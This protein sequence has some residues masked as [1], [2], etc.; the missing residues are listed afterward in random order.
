MVF[1]KTRKA[2]R[3]SLPLIRRL[4]R[5][6]NVETD[7]QR[8]H[9]VNITGEQVADGAAA[10]TEAP[11]D[12]PSQT[13]RSTGH[14]D[15]GTLDRTP[16]VIQDDVIECIL[17]ELEIQA[18]GTE[19]DESRIDE[20]SPAAANS[21]TANNTNQAQISSDVS[22]DSPGDI[23]V[24][25][26]PRLIYPVLAVGALTTLAVVI[27]S[28]YLFS[29]LETRMHGPVIRLYN[30]HIHLGI[31]GLVGGNAKIDYI[32]TGFFCLLF[33]GT[34]LWFAVMTHREV[35]GRHAGENIAMESMT[36][37]SG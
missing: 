34:L 6:Q 31:R 32:S 8:H 35:V 3:R 5:G 29:S 22:I 18:A 1:T 17:E 23:D 24:F 11:T 10:E 12:A 9:S 26:N 30:D 36:F 7:S 4:R 20:T 13:E 25:F 19:A 14:T 2:V 16:A 33:Y 21:Q 15:D 28:V 37:G 27:S